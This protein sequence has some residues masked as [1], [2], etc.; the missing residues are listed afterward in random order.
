ME[1][2]FLCKILKEHS[3][4]EKVW[5]FIVN[6]LSNVYIFNITQR[7]KQYSKFEYVVSMKYFYSVKFSKSPDEV[8]NTHT[9]LSGLSKVG[10]NYNFFI[11]CRRNTSIN[12]GCGCS[13]KNQNVTD[14]L[15]PETSLGSF[16]V[17][18]FL[19]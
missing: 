15:P 9:T 8:T 17:F 12:N 5:D 16:V 19:T 6:I 11:Y 1:L 10:K 7:C 13:S 18:L 2:G 3:N 4:E 14:S